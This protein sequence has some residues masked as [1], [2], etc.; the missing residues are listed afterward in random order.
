MGSETG[1]PAS[2]IAFWTAV[3]KLLLKSLYYVFAV[4]VKLFLIVSS[5]LG[6]VG[7]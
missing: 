3:A 4:L 2:T 7:M 1:M 6:V 5:C